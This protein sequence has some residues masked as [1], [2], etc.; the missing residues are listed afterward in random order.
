MILKPA[1]RTALERALSMLNSVE[2]PLAFME[3]IA[4]VSPLYQERVKQQR[5]R[6]T[7]VKTLAETAIVADSSSARS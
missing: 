7:Y 3:T 2:E 6:N 1:Q 4:N 5:E